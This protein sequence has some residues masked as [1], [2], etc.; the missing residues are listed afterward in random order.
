MYDKLNRF[1]KIVFDCVSRRPGSFLL[2]FGSVTTGIHPVSPGHIRHHY[3]YSG[4]F[5][6]KSKSK[7]HAGR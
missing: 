6:I 5:S 1:E 3:L 4:V 7:D 2:L